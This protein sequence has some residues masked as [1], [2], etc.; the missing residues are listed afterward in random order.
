M[1]DPG[2]ALHPTAFPPDW[3]R[4]DRLAL[5]VPELRR[6]A[7]TLRLSLIHI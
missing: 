3:Q 5:P 1:T 6:V 4:R 2:S 7:H